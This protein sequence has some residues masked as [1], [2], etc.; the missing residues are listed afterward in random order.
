MIY[1]FLTVLFYKVEHHFAIYEEGE[2][3]DDKKKRIQEIH[4]DATLWL[5]LISG[6]IIAWKEVLI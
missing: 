2:H 1:F 5:L 6:L 3:V 4:E